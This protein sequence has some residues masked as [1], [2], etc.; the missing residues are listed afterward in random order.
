VFFALT[1]RMAKR[2]QGGVDR[3]MTSNR[4]QAYGFQTRWEDIDVIVSRRKERRIERKIVI[5]GP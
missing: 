2:F 5:Q 1:I 3:F 4:I